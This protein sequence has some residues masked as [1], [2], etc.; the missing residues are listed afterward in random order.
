M[1]EENLQINGADGEVEEKSNKK[2]ANTGIGQNE[3][4]HKI[5]S[6]HM[7]SSA[8]AASLATTE[9]DGLGTLPGQADWCKTEMVLPVRSY[10]VC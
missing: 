5:N 8:I 2:A 3:T 4:R 7:T 10:G 9:L 6:A 1:I